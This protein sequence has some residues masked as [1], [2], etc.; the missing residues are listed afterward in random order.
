M[1]EGIR[2]E[3]RQEAAPLSARLPDALGA[4]LLYAGIW[5]AL[6]S[7]AGLP[8]ASLLCLLPG[9]VAV[10]FPLLPP[11]AKKLWA[12]LF[13]AWGL[14]ALL[15]LLVNPGTAL[16]G[17][18]IL[19]NR[20]CEAS[21][22]RQAY[23]YTLFPVSA[24]PGKQ[25]F[26][27]GYALL[28]L[29]LLSGIV[30]GAVRR[31]RWLI[32]ALPLAVGG[33]VA[34]LGVS[35]GALPLCLLAAGLTLT[36][37]A[38]GRADLRGCAAALAAVLAVFGIVSAAFPGE[39]AALSAWEERTRDALAFHTSAVAPEELPRP[40]EP[41]RE[42]EERPFWAE[43]TAGELGGDALALPR[44]PRAL[45]IILLLALVLFVPSLASDWLKRRR[46]KNRAGLDDP[47]PGR[48]VRAGFRYAMRWLYA[49]GLPEA[50]V[51]YSGY[52][53][54]IGERFSPELRARFEAVLP[55]WQEAA[56]SDHPLDGAARERMGAFVE[57]ARTAAWSGM[58]RRGRLRAK[59]FEAL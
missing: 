2:C 16:D 41:E 11:G 9:G 55:L 56:Y 51:P 12:G 45:W 37:R 47:D 50:N 54:A 10:L 35:P 49:A 46:A 5:S 23:V 52:A 22:A 58:D 7:M 3:A 28:V 13:A 48:A 17:A 59:Y 32:V 24:A 43:E 4:A 1:S 6:C 34:Y 21:Q 26:C 8:A 57:Q 18:R 38:P 30:C 25:G 40:A 36:L 44:P 42:R 19:L 20:L 53:G 14:A 31:A 15:L 27:L 33:A 29:G 39:D